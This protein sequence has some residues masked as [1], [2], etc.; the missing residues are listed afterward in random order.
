MRK[1]SRVSTLATFFIGTML[2]GPS[3]TM[4]ADLPSFI[5]ADCHLSKYYMK[6]IN[7]EWVIDQGTVFYQ[8][9][10]NLSR[11][12]RQQP[13]GSNVPSWAGS[14]VI[15]IKDG[16]ALDVT[17]DFMKNRLIGDFEQPDPAIALDAKLIYTR[18]NKQ[19]LSSTTVEGSIVTTD[20]SFVTASATINDAEL[21]TLL[22]RTGIAI[23]P[24]LEYSGGFRYWAAIRD[25]FGDA[26]NA[27]ELSDF[28]K[29]LGRASN[30]IVPSVSVTCNLK[31]PGM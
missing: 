3:P 1:V 6:P 30:L 26:L 8:E 18:N 9:S 11:R 31:R 22:A 13:F 29:P 27:S 25:H 17:I 7:A 28:L 4:A 21:E 12:D 5:T 15:D 16:Y 20:T 10:V 2:A 23:P 19:V 14:R 24:P